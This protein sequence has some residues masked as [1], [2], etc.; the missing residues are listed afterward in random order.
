[1]LPTVSGE[2]RAVAEPELKFAPSG[3]AYC[4]VRGVADKK[5]KEGDQWV[6]DKII[7]VNIT[8]FGKTAENMAESIIKGTLMYVVG[9]IEQRE[10]ETQAGEKRTSIDIAASSVSVS[11]AFD[12]AHVVKGERA[13]TPARATNPA[14]DP[15][16]TGPQPA[17]AWGGAGSAQTEAPPFSEGF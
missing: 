1:M 9:T 10:Y 3:M 12:A 14:S 11:L 7:W 4:R 5:K 8:G 16:S 17:D 6:D 13:A 2:F 15:W